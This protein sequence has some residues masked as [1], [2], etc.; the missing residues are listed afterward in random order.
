PV[1][2]PPTNPLAWNVAPFRLNSGL[3]SLNDKP[4]GPPELRNRL[5]SARC[6]WIGVMLRGCSNCDCSSSLTRAIS[7]RCNA[8]YESARNRCAE[9]VLGSVFTDFQP[10]TTA[11]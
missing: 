7:W 1:L 4:V 6:G 3:N 11:K 8:E 5:L 9:K 2:L 10:S